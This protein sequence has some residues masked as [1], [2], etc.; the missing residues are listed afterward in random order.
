MIPADEL[1]RMVRAVRPGWSVRRAEPVDRGHTAVHWL[2][3][4]DGG[5]ARRVLLK[6]SPDHGSHGIDTERR[7]LA[8]LDRH[9]TIPV[10]RVFGGLDDHEQ[11]S[12]PYFL[13]EALPGSSLPFQ[14]TRRLSETA[15]ERLAHQTG[16]YLAELH[17]LPA[18]EAFGV[19]G[20]AADGDAASLGSLEVR[21]PVEDWSTFLRRSFEPELDA[22]G[23][24]RFDD[25]EAAVSGRFHS[26]VDDLEISRRPVLGRIDHG[27]HNLLLGAER[28][29]IEAVIDWG[30]T[31]AV[32]PGYDL[33]T[34][35]YVLS[36]AVLAPLEDATDRRPLVREAMTE[37]YRDTRAYPE[38][39]LAAAGELYELMAVV[40]SMN[41]LD[42]GLAKVPAG[43]E[44]RVADGLR[45][46][47]DRLR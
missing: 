20:H 46:D 13:M 19:L 16:R 11:L 26:G 39:E 23:D 4:T 47:L 21:E 42:A 6:A 38:D 24:S 28:A 10:P 44:D 5:T 27:V 43:T 1:E 29:E 25:V 9:T 41:H 15:L 12:S 8:V 18:V 30:F 14:Q 35:E 33:R 37:G 7:L 3:V 32:T 22:L 31:L 2:E 40:R 34:V 36:G 17:D 45:K